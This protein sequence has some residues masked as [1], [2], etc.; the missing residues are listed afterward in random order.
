MFRFEDRISKRNFIRSQSDRLQSQ[1]DHVDAQLYRLRL[2]KDVDAD[3]ALGQ[4]YV[5]EYVV[6]MLD[7]I[8]K[9]YETE[10]R[11]RIGLALHERPFVSYAARR[12]ARSRDEAK[13][14]FLTLSRSEQSGARPQGFLDGYAD[15]VSA[16]YDGASPRRLLEHFIEAARPPHEAEVRPQ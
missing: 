9:M 6:G 14:R 10:T 15:G 7:A 8:T 1:L 3:R 16:L 4:S 2:R 13:T 5:D 11:R 12:L